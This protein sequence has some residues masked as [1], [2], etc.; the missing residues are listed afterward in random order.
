MFQLS[1]HDF[2]AVR[3]RCRKQGDHISLSCKYRYHPRNE[4]DEC[5]VLWRHRLYK[6]CIILGQGWNLEA[7]LPC[8]SGRRIFA[9]YQDFSRPQRHVVWKVSSILQEH[10]D[11]RHTIAEI[12]GEVIRQP[13]TWKGRALN[14]SKAK[15]TSN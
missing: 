13:H 4:Q 3:P 2:A 5:Q 6:D 14:L 9:F 11:R 10:S 8:L 7:P 15:P 1:H 12:Y